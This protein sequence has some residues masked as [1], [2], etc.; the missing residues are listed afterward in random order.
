MMDNNK[1]ALA[2]VIALA[3]GTGAFLRDVTQPTP[4]VIVHGDGAFLTNMT[5]ENTFLEI[6]AKDALLSNLYFDG[7]KAGY[8][9]PAVSKAQVCPTGSVCT[10]RGAWELFSPPAGSP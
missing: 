7:P 9:M 10:D 4:R 2:A 8:I 1:V 6:A 5:F 3:M